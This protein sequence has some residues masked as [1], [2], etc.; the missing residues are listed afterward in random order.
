MVDKQ[1]KWCWQEILF[2]L[3]V[4]IG[5]FSFFTVAHPLVPYDGDDW[6]LLSSM[7]RAVPLLSTYNPIKILPEDLFPLVGTFSANI[8]FPLIGDY[9]YSIIIVSSTVFSLL[10]CVYL[11]QFYQFI[12]KAFSLES[13]TVILITALFLLFHFTLFYSKSSVSIYL[14]RTH[15][16]TCL[17]H[18]VI[19]AIVNISL[20]LYLARFDFMSLDYKENPVVPCKQRNVYARSLSSWSGL[21]FVVYLAIF[22]NILSSIILASYVFSVLLLRFLQKQH[23]DREYKAFA[24]DNF[25]YIGILLVWLI[26]LFFEAHGGRAHDIGHNIFSLPIVETGKHLLVIL[27]KLSKDFI[28]LALLLSVGGLLVSY[29]KKADGYLAF[30]KIYVLTSII[31][32]PYLLLIC[33]KAAPSYMERSDVFISFI[34]WTLLFSCL[35]LAYLIKQMPKIS[36]LLPIAVLYFVIEAIG[37]NGFQENVISN[38]LSEKEC[39]SVDREI[40]QQLQDADR[41]GENEVILRVPKGDNRD[42]WPHPLY[43][44]KALSRTMYKHGL[45][46]RQLKITIQ[47]D[48]DMNKKYHISIKE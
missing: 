6:A 1:C 27:S 23:T 24:K 26:S 3:S 33:A 40:I 11:Y 29:K 44:G 2:F 47:P 9:I 41:N 42:N 38:G 25:L 34:I 36:I 18:Y 15:D 32:L 28:L 46:S 14:F 20:V 7:R 48:L 8:I 37:G 13:S 45:I 21:I 16:L 5:I 4:F 10:I 31:S 35:S 17:Y 30:F 19:P 43:M 22:S 12:K 39:I